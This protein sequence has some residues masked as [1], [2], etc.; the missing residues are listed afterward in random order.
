MFVRA[1]RAALAAVAILALAV[2]VT[3][4]A[5][6][7]AVTI[8][9]DAPFG[10]GSESFTA[11]GAFCDAGTAETFDLRIV[12]RRSAASFHLN[13]TLTCTDGSGTL[14]ISV[15][16]ATRFGK[17]G[18]QGGWAVISGTGDWAG[19]SGGGVLVG[20]YYDGGVIDVYAGSIKLP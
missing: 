7:S 1:A 18:D 17:P 14:T 3:G 4:A 19:A 8:T 13:K 16:A 9:L 12:G 2:P 11:A 10:G 15:D 5:Q 6:P 20:T